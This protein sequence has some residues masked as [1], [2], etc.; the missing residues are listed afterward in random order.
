L[1]GGLDINVTGELSAKQD[2][3]IIE[4]DRAKNK[5]YNSRRLDFVT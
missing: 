1:G 4:F 2:K 5:V 3:F